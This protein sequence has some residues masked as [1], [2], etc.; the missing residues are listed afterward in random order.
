VIR[1]DTPA[2]MVFT[3]SEAVGLGADDGSIPDG[4]ACFLDKAKAEEMAAQCGGHLE[5]DRLGVFVESNAAIGFH[6]IMVDLD[7]QYHYVTEPGG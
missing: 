5:T 1:Y 2:W 3:E 4:L 6:T 7:G